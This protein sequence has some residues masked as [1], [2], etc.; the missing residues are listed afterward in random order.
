MGI[1]QTNNKKPLIQCLNRLRCWPIIGWSSD[2][3]RLSRPY[4]VLEHPPSCAISRQIPGTPYQSGLL[5]IRYYVPG[6][7][8]IKSSTT[9]E[10][11]YRRCMR[12]NKHDVKI[13]SSSDKI[14]RLSFRFVEY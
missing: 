1:L 5:Q 6:T 4:P 8:H 7:P 10:M 13:S 2:G 12:S 14:S 9:M 11:K 3:S